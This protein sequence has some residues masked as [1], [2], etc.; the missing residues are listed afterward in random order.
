[1]KVSI[2]YSNHNRVE[3]M[4][5]GLAYLDRQSLPKGEFEVVVVD[6]GS[7]D[8][9]EK[10]LEPFRGKLCMQWIRI[11]HTRHPIYAE[12]NPSGKPLH[13]PSDVPLWYHTPALTHNMA[14]RHARGEVLCITQPEVLYH[15][16]A[17]ERGYA[18]AMS[19]QRFVFGRPWMSL[20]SFRER[21][22]KL[23]ASGEVP[24]Y[25]A[26][27][28]MP[29]YKKDEM[30]NGRLKENVGGGVS[31]PHFYWWVS[32]VQKSAVDAIGGVDEEYLRGVY[33][34]DDDF[35]FRLSRAGWPPE[36]RID[37]IEGIHLNHDHLKGH[38]DRGHVRWV[39]GAKRNRAR[40]AKIGSLPNAA[41]AGRTWGDPALIERHET[42]DL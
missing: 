1:M 33:A 4:Q 9:Y 19:V 38:W 20:P 36:Y 12:L 7:T 10:A 25:D 8:D 21:V 41:N 39:E 11:D 28:A 42:W 6:D 26:L 24:P 5:A 2:V 23:L 16:N 34:E 29:D 31:N 17:M 35:R 37:Q 40:W 14:F 22:L 13:E 18:A 32:F 30:Q 3:L 15:P 27:K